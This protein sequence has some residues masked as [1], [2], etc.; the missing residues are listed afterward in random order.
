MSDVST[1]ISDMKDLDIMPSRGVDCIKYN[2]KYYKLGPGYL[3]HDGAVI[4]SVDELDDGL[5]TFILFVDSSFK[6]RPFTRSF[7]RKVAVGKQESILNE[8]ELVRNLVNA[9]C[10]NEKSACERIL[11]YL[12]IGVARCHTLWEEG[13]KHSSIVLGYMEKEDFIV[14]AGEMKKEGNVAYVNAFSGTYALPVLE[15]IARSARTIDRSAKSRMMAANSRYLNCI[16]FLLDVLSKKTRIE[17]VPDVLITEENTKPY[18]KARIQDFH[19]NNR[20]IYR[21]DSIDE[22]NKNVMRAKMRIITRIRQMERKR[23]LLLRMK[24][25]V[26]TVDAA[27]IELKNELNNLEETVW[28]GE[29]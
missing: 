4:Q 2:D 19:D 27:I 18:V 14:S 20:P 22:C 28:N 25:K 10:Q 5:Y 8:V 24:R 6:K 1:L 3:V 26:D 23:A 29:W 7:T 21:Y 13:T 16:V 9:C 17:P 15:E 11:P 12:R